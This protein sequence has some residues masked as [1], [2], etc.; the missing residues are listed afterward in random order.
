MSSKTACLRLTHVKTTGCYAQD[1]HG[2]HWASW[3]GPAVA[4]AV[5]GASIE[6]GWWRALSDECV[7]GGHIAWI[8]G[9]A[10]SVSMRMLTL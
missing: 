7:C 1:E 2:R 5:C 3:S 10:E 8:P 4:C 6:R 9:C